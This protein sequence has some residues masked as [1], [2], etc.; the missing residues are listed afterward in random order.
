MNPRINKGTISARKGF[1]RNALITSIIS[2]METRKWQPSEEEREVM[3]AFWMQFKGACKKLKEETN[4]QDE[5]IRKM[6]QEMADRYY[7]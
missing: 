2:Y 4:A 1:I 5:H 7:S 3:E 6:L